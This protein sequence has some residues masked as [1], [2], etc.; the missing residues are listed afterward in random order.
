M[1]GFVVDV[2]HLHNRFERV[3]L[4]SAGVR[5]LAEE[6]LFLEIADDSIRDKSKADWLAKALVCIQVLWLVLQILDR[7]VFGLPIALIELHTAIHVACALILY[8]FWFHKPKDINDPTVIESSRFEGQLAHALVTDH[9]LRETWELIEVSRNQL[10]S[11]SPKSTSCTEDD[12][13]GI[14]ACQRM[15]E[16][17]VETR[18]DEID[19]N[20]PL[21]NRPDFHP[22]NDVQIFLQRETAVYDRVLYT[23]PD[24]TSSEMRL[25]RRDTA[26]SISGW[27]KESSKMADGWSQIYLSS[28]DILRWNTALQYL[29]RRGDVHRD[30]PSSFTARAVNSG[31]SFFLYRHN[32]GALWYPLSVIWEAEHLLARVHRTIHDLSVPKLGTILVVTVLPSCYAGLHM[33]AWDFLFPTEAEKVLW[34][35]CSALLLTQ[36]L[37]VLVSSLRVK[38]LSPILRKP[39]WLTKTLCGPFRSLIYFVTPTHAEAG[40]GFWERATFKATYA[41]G[42]VLV[43]CLWVL[44]PVFLSARV[45]LVV[46]SFISLRHVP[47]GVYAPAPWTSYIP[48]L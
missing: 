11:E 14:Y 16:V 42:I 29:L 26:N 30:H 13:L 20:Q 17:C 22:G 39:K 33:A 41:M 31:E 38:W 27:S 34:R 7:V 25:L 18:K 32:V 3:T 44:V 8:T 40:C 37:V 45:F 23:S 47:A 36:P 48:H 28:K 43:G 5:L 6:G 15:E 21:R 1:G 2:R 9:A 24:D 35:I 10:K 12:C 19:L 4:T 46:E